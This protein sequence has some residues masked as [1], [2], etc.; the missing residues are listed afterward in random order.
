MTDFRATL[1]ARLGGYGSAPFIR[2]DRT[3]YSG[4]DI[5]AYIT[6]VEDHLARAGVGADEPVGLVVRNRV[7]HAAAILGFIAAAARS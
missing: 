1:S 3:W 5:T 6:R 4:N 2:F 7:P